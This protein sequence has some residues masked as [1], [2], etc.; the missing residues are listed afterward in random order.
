[1]TTDSWFDRLAL[2]QSRGHFLKTALASGAVLTLPQARAARASVSNDF[3]CWRGCFYT[4]H[5][6]QQTDLDNCLTKYQQ[7]A[8][9]VGKRVFWIP[10]LGGAA[11]P[12]VQKGCEA[13]YQNKIAKCYDLALLKEK[14]MERDC[15]EP[16]CPGF[17]PEAPD[18]PC[19]FVKKTGGHCC[20]DPKSVTGY[21]GCSECCSA[22]GDG[23][24]SGDTACEGRR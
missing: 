11:V 15:L 1:M 24:A 14:A 21:S 19:A 17:D 20:P 23:C 6:R 2:R 13:V 10:I 4:A 7:C 16:N 5:V 18:G 9:A 12:L 22:T 3:D 8:S